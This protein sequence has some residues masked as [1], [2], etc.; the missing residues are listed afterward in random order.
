M[1]ARVMRDD[2]ARQLRALLRRAEDLL[3]RDRE[4]R[5]L[6]DQWSMRADEHARTAE[7]KPS[8]RRALEADGCPPEL[9]SELAGAAWQLEAAHRRW[10]AQDLDRAQTELLA[11]LAVVGFSDPAPLAGLLD[12]LA[13]VGGK[14]D[15]IGHAALR[16]AAIVALRTAGA[17]SPA[18]LVDAALGERRA[19]R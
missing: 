18:R 2:T 9:V 11:A 14:L 13:F 1:T 7:D 8:L 6:H 10:L 16:Q 19:P 17:S 3:R 4:R 15:V 12:D 5:E